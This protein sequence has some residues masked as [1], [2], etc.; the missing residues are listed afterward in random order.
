MQAQ[1]TAATSSW[2]RWLGQRIAIGAIAGTAIMAAYS[3]LAPKFE[4]LR[5]VMTRLTI[6]DTGSFDGSPWIMGLILWLL[7]VI[8]GVILWGIAR[9]V[10]KNADDP[11]RRENLTTGVGIDHGHR[12][13]DF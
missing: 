2:R 4:Q 13:W 10:T 9:Q 11:D 8:T 1:A 5:R 3:G 12:T 7:A 6:R